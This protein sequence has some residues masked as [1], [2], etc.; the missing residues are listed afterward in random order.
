V[1]E[2]QKPED[3]KEQLIPPLGGGMGPAIFVVLI[4]LVGYLVYQA[5]LLFFG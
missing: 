1:E 2:D 4:V 5:Y 3:E